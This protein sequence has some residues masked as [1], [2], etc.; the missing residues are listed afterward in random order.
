METPDH[1]EWRSRQQIHWPAVAKASLIAGA[2]VFFFSGG[3]PWSTAGTMN[4][5]MGRDLPIAMLLLFVLHFLFAF[6]YG[7]IIAAII[8]RLRLVLSLMAGLGTG[9][10]LYAVNF[11]IFHFLTIQMQSPE[12]RAFYVHV[13]FGL[14]VSAAY[15]ALSVPKPFRGDEREVEEKTHRVLLATNGFDPEPMPAADR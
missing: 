6:V 4:A 9:L 5:I 3:S 8:Y 12:A 2:V 14:L 10:A 13:T 11:A 1:Q 15:K 7:G